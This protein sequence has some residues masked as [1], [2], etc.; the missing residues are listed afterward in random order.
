MASG[1]Y[2]IEVSVTQHGEDADVFF[3]GKVVVEGPPGARSAFVEGG[4]WMWNP[5]TEEWLPPDG[6][7]QTDLDK[8]ADAL[9]DDALED[10]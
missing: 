6:I 3:L 1:N 9:C 10:G 2:E 7:P 5:E 8:A 4:V